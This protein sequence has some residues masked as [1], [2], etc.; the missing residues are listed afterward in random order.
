MVGVNCAKLRGY[1][2][3][4]KNQNK[5]KMYATSVQTRAG[6]CKHTSEHEVHIRARSFEAGALLLG[7]YMYRSQSA[8]PNRLFI[9]YFIFPGRATWLRK[10][11]TQRYGE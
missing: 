1:L 9:L 8:P 4:V 6:G 2:A 11:F 10:R 7:T 3:L 5:K